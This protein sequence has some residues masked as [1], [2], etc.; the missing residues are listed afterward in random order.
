MRSRTQ[1][2][3]ADS[4]SLMI[5][6]RNI[7]RHHQEHGGDLIGDG[8]ATSGAARP[9]GILIPKISPKKP[10]VDQV[11]MMIKL[12]QGPAGMR[13]IAGGESTLIAAARF[14]PASDCIHRPGTRLLD[15]MT[16]ALRPPNLKRSGGS[17]W[18][19]ALH[20]APWNSWR[21]SKHARDSITLFHRFACRRRPGASP[22]E[23]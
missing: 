1:Q 12:S 16:D 17:P 7:I 14:V 3:R 10:R 6:S 15:P 18:I 9:T 5:P 13:D 23:S 20:R 8:S 11:Q 22:L 21:S 19:Q 2:G 4:F